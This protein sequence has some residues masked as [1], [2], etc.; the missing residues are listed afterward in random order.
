MT[1]Q[2]GLNWRKAK[3]EEMRKDMVEE[4]WGNLMGDRNTEE[5]WRCFRQK[6]YA[7]VDKHVPRFVNV[8]KRR[9]DW[10]TLELLRQIRKK[11]RMWKICVRLGGAENER[12]YKEQEKKVANLVRIAKRG[13]EKRLANDKEDKN[14]RKFTK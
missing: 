6:M 10:I 2:N 3:F 7:I 14:R 12:K 8:R 4:E 9:P 13:M 11:K 1:V 5:T